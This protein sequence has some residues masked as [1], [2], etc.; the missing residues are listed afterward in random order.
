[1]TTEGFIAT[2]RDRITGAARITTA[3]HPTR[4]AAARAALAADPKA[5]TVA[6]EIARRGVATGSD[7][8]WHSRASLL[9]PR[10]IV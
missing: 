8:Q 7:I 3:V 6:T 2:T 10:L 9:R 5:K 4:D 1:M